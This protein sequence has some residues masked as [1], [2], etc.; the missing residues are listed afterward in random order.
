[1]KTMS[2][3]E[4][5]NAFGQFLEAAQR[6]PVAVT[7]NRRM[8]A[9]LFSMEDLASLARTCLSE[10]LR[11][12][13]AAGEISVTAAL[14]RQARIN[15]RIAQSR[16]EAATGKTITMDDG[17]FAKLRAHVRAVSPVKSE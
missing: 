16:E 14:I 2:A 15:D 6:E 13:V 3:L 4:A 12:Q 17:Y 10:P 5:K 1:M 7:K 11:E 8:V 9:A